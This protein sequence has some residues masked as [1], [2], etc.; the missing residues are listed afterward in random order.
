MNKIFN[1]DLSSKRI[2]VHFIIL[3]FV[4]LVNLFIV[5]IF[6]RTLIRLGGA[7]F[8][9]YLI[10]FALYGLLIAIFSSLQLVVIIPTFERTK[11][12]TDPT[13]NPARIDYSS[14]ERKFKV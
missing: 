3:G 11:H 1:S 14:K 2:V 6:I 13:D 12:Y 5:Y 4:T 7:D 9:T 8:D 10:A